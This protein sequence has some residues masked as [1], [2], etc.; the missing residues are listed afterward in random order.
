M[1]M[2]ARL[3][4][5]ISVLAVTTAGVSSQVVR[6]VG[7]LGPSTATGLSTKNGQALINGIAVDTNAV[8]LANAT[9][10]LRNLA[11]NNIDQVTSANHLGQFTFIA[12]PEIPYVVEIADR[13]GRILAVGDII[14]AQAGDVASAVVAIPTRLPAV[15]GVFGET[16]SSVLTAA[17]GI[18]IPVSASDPPLSPE[19]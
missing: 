12:R 6:P 4:L 1:I 13:V 18:G 14:T 2:G 15:A 11:A 8:P 9:V 7:P 3:F 17:T 16:A 5:L 19:K 10:R